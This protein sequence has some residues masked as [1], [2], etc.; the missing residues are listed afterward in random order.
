MNVHTFMAVLCRLEELNRQGFL[1]DKQF[2]KALKKLRKRYN[3][4]K[5]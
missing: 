3:H 5:H 2:A 1:T 4:E